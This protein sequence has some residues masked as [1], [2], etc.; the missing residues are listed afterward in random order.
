MS[1]SGKNEFLSSLCISQRMLLVNESGLKLLHFLSI[2]YMMTSSN[3]NI[4][5]VTGPLCGEFTGPGEFHA[6]RPVTRS[7]DVFFDLR[8]NKRLS[9]QPW[10][11]WF[12]TPSWSLWRQCNEKSCFFGDPWYTHVPQSSWHNKNARV[13]ESNKAF[14]LIYSCTSIILLLYLKNNGCNIYMWSHTGSC[15][16]EEST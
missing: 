10:G 2:P 5:R 8:P 13:M 1:I 14:S 15:C 16:L 12:E 6:Q 11:W 7:F 4:F 3:G 9:K